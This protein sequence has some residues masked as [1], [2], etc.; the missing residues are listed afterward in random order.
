M[1]EQPEHKQKKVI[2]ITVIVRA[3]TY[4]ILTVFQ[5]LFLILFI[6]INLIF[7]TTLWCRYLELRILRHE[8]VTHPRSQSWWLMK[9]GLKGKGPCYENHAPNHMWFKYHYVHRLIWIQK[10]PN[11]FLKTAETLVIKLGWKEFFPVSL[12]R[13][14][15]QLD[16]GRWWAESMLG[17]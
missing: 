17:F 6:Y 15:N 5:A 2:M 14:K 9:Q 16:M 11:D 1:L 13:C 12:P 8:E 4:L 7:K 3:N 10:K